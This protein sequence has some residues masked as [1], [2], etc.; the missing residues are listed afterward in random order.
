MRAD[1]LLAILL[2]LQNRG[3]MTAHALSEELGVSI[4]TMYRD[5]DALSAAGAPIYADRGPGGGWNLL[6]S[7][8]SSF[9]WF[10]ETEL[11]LLF[12][13]T[14]THPMDDLFE[15]N[16][17]QMLW[18]K[19]FSAL[20]D[21]QRRYTEEV[22]QRLFLDTERWWNHRETVPFLQILHN[23]V[24]TQ[25][26]VQISYRR[27]NDTVVTRL[28]HPLGLVSKG[29]IWYVVGATEQVTRVYRVSRIQHCLPTEEHFERPVNF[30]LA[31]FWKEWQRDFLQTFSPVVVT[32]QTNRE[33]IRL[34]VKVLGE[35]IQ[36]LV[37]RA[38]PLWK[39]ETGE[40]Q[41]PFESQ[42]TALRILLGLG[43]AIE[44]ISPPELRKQFQ[45]VAFSITSLYSQ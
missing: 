45:K 10:T 37:E 33:G 29:Y 12:T 2:L 18:L 36:Q 5:L 39:G 13:P 35:E 43:T 21:A 4:R 16:A 7:Y 25:Q 32:L 19:L 41:L 28:I 31:R 24:W 34:L 22:Q 17:P 44:V 26:Q 30:D 42:D 40:L 1:R 8:R 27:S 11:R 15:Q 14:Q 9:S 23:A 38:E 20:P 3:R 6:K